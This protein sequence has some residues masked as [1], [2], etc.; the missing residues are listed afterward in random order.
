[1][2]RRIYG[3]IPGPTWERVTAMVVIALSALALLVVFYEWA[4]N[5][6]LDTGGRI[7]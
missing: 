5:T 3:L 7:G 4:G 2:I 6:F 1:M